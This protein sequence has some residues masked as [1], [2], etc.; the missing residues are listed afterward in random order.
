MK[1]N[2]SKHLL[3]VKLMQEELQENA[4]LQ[5]YR[6]A[7]LNLL[8]HG[9]AYYYFFVLGHESE[10]DDGLFHSHAY[11]SASGYLIEKNFL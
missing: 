2:K 1:S 11:E 9:N 8:K 6:A 10:S 4:N 5:L 7:I 3:K